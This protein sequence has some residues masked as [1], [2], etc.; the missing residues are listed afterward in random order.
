M[1]QTMSESDKKFAE[2]LNA[3]FIKHGK[4]IVPEFVPTL[5]IIP[6]P[7]QQVGATPG[8]QTPGQEAPAQ[9]PVE[10]AVP[11]PVQASDLGSNGAT[12]AAQA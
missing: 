6:L 7:P 1:E 5:R 2:E 12:G 9:A 4:T 8:A 11:S 10:G 3:L